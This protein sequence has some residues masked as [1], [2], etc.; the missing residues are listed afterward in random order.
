MNCSHWWRS[1]ISIHL[2][3]KLHALL[4][5]EFAGIHVKLALLPAGTLLRVN[6]EKLGSVVEGQTDLVPSEEVPGTSA[7]TA[8]NLSQCLHPFNRKGGREDIQVTDLP[9]VYFVVDWT[10]LKCYGPWSPIQ[11]H[12]IFLNLV[13]NELG[14]QSH[15]DSTSEGVQG[16]AE[17]YPLQRECG[18]TDDRINQ[19]VGVSFWDLH[20]CLFLPNWHADN[21]PFIL[22][23]YCQKRVVAQ[24]EGKDLIQS[25][26]NCEGGEKIRWLVFFDLCIA[27]GREMNNC[28]FASACLTQSYYTTEEEQEK[29]NPGHFFLG[30]L[31]LYDW[32]VYQWTT[33]PFIPETN[34]PL[35]QRM[36]NTICK[37][38]YKLSLKTNTPV[39]CPII[40]HDCTMGLKHK[41]VNC[42]TCITNYILSYQSYYITEQKNKGKERLSILSCLHYWLFLWMKCL[43][44]D[45]IHSNSNTCLPNNGAQLWGPKKTPSANI[46]S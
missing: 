45:N 19:L 18:F 14:I 22:C 38:Y 12:K 35:C 21:K 4:L 32:S 17:H 11:T 39:T 16:K 46:T 10:Q 7:L 20:N 13:K 23:I 43:P 40:D 27:S 2:L 26:A 36:G 33:R 34:L 44:V 5:V 15:P 6:L 3:T 25:R 1:P 9:W 24:S 8:P 28:G 37:L 30:V 41:N 31:I 42:T 29:R